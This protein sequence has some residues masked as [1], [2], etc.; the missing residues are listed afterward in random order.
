MDHLKNP[1]QEFQNSF[2][3]KFVWISRK[4]GRQK[5]RDG[6]FFCVNKSDIAVC[7]TWGNKNNLFRENVIFAIP[8]QP[9]ICILPKFFSKFAFEV[10]LILFVFKAKMLKNKNDVLD[11]FKYLKYFK[12][13][14]LGLFGEIAKF[15]IN[16]IFI[17]IEFSYQFA[18]RLIEI[19]LKIQMF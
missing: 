1:S 13:Q 2:C 17:S 19:Y 16:W 4:T 5:I 3:F 14:I 9:L 15:W 6:I 8:T 7:V 10:L 11:Y 12:I 18:R